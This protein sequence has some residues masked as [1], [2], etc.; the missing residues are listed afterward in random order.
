MKKILV[1]GLIVLLAAGLTGLILVRKFE[2]PPGLGISTEFALRQGWGVRDAAQAL[3]QSGLVRSRWMVLLHYRLN[4]QGSSLQAGNYIL[5]DTMQVDSILAKFISGDVIPVATSWV[6][7]PP[8]LRMEESLQVISE[9]LGIPLS[10]LEDLSREIEFLEAMGIPCFE[11]Y[12]F[13]ETYEFA[14]S[15]PPWNVIDTIV[16]T[17]FEVMDA[18]WDE[19]C[20]ALG[21]SSF[22][23]VILASIVEREAASDAERDLVAGVFLNRLRISMRLESCAT[24]QYA[25]G[26]VKEILLYSDLEIESPFNTY[27]NAGL[28]PS[29]IC[30][31]GTASLEAVANPDT[32]GG[33]LFFVSKGDGSGEHLFAVTAAG[34][35]RNIR[36][37]R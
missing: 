9:S 24:V 20:E 2:S 14:D 1:K 3:E 33:Y 37:V 19:K 4:F 32:T 18:E 27:R 36:L 17:G 16:R 11:G 30:S 34:H 10:E 23:S 13:P 12:L 28:P 5:S 22:D 21:L 35:A 8:G 6:T 26:E 15:M 29:P 31:P 7:L 25:L